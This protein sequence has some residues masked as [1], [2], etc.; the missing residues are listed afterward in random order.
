MNGAELLLQ[1]L[2]E[3]GVEVAFANPGTSEMH[4]VAALDKQDGIRGVLGLFEG[5]VTGAADG[6]ARMAGKPACTLLHLGPGLANGIANL[7]NARRA[8]APIVNIVGEHATY[9]RALDAPLTSDIESLA[10]P[11]SGWLRVCRRAEDAAGDAAAAVA[12]SLAPPGQIATLILPADAAWNETDRGAKPVAVSP[13]RS[14]EAEPIEGAI[15]ALRSGEPC[16]FLVN[17][18]GAREDA[19]RMLGQ[20]AQTTGAALLGDTFIARVEQGAGRVALP[21]LPYFAEGAEETL[22]GIRHLI[23]VDTRAPVSF[24]AYPGRQSEL[25][26]K[27]ATVHALTAPGDDTHAALRA[28][29]EGVGAAAA[30]PGGTVSERPALP[31]GEL[32]PLTIAQAVAALMPE[33][34]VVVN[35]AATAG[36]AFPAITRGAAQHDWLDLTGGSIGMGIPVATGAAVACPGRRVIGL[37]ADGSGMYTVQGLWSQAREGLDV[38]TVVFSN[39]KYAILQVEFARVGAEPGPKALE[40]LDLTRPDL[41]WVDLARGLGVPGTRATTADEFAAAFERSLATAGPAL[42]ECAL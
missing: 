6:Y 32:T 2:V 38:T 3:A 39:R 4:F 14:P 8:R 15:A 36:F 24:F 25:T 5:V 40:L 13:R 17:G 23:L 18:L 22:R 30:D 10:R 7:H 12:A 35:E 29:L 16:A 27:G 42:I 11:V 20:I 26:P 19:L 1:T 34:A 9:H 37:Q 41:G 21:R 33:G 28:V 31:R